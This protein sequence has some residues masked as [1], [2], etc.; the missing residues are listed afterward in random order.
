VSY[1]DFMMVSIFLVCSSWTGY[2]EGQDI[3][4]VGDS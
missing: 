1:A 4:Q 2:E 3:L